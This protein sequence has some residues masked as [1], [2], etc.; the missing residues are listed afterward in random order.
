MGMTNF[1]LLIQRYSEVTERVFL[2][3]ASVGECG[4]AFENMQLVERL[5]PSPTPTGRLQD[6]D[7]V[8][9][10]RCGRSDIKCAAGA[11]V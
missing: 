10:E 9:H 3:C 8:N 2:I 7:L 1:R 11:R 4:L 5:H 6:L